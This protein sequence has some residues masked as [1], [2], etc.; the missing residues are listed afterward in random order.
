MATDF[1]AEGLLEGLEGERAREARL[2][3]LRRLEDD[4]YSLDEL[5]Q[6][7]A[8]NRLVLLPVER[9]LDGGGKRYTSGQVAEAA[10]LEEDFVRRLWR[11]LG[12][13]QA[14]S[15]DPV[16]GEEDV[17]A[18]SALKRFRDAGIP[19]EDILEIA[20]V[21]SQGVANVAGAVQ[22]PFAQAFLR[23]GD[24]EL[25]VALRMAEA[26]EE[27]NPLLGQTLVR[28]LHV[29]QR[30]F[31]RNAA[32]GAAELSS[33][34]LAGAQPVAVCFADM[35][36]FTRLGERIPP[37]DLGVLAGRL[38]ELAASVAAPPVRLV[39]TIGD[40]AM[41]VSPDVDALIAAA[42][43]LVE[44]AAAEPDFP[45]LRAGVAFGPALPRA[46]DWYGQPVNLASRITSFAKPGSVVASEA[47]REAAEGG[48]RWSF[49]GKRKFKNVKGEIAVYRVRRAEE[50]SR[51]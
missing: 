13:A 3:L 17:E 34:T 10:G 35:V 8:E 44:A 49:A 25:D 14:D 33:G 47:A 39:K 9:V 51:P 5:R 22:R 4:G 28:A 37:E 16:A 31:A 15:G 48:Y 18:A 27:L 26:A 40:A 46:G 20:R 29:H 36:G 24:T 21:M 32:L 12:M 38:S 45:E 7:A 43:Q 42:L 11:A 41:L 6:A 19:E 30:E 2:E 23:G 50:G 1:E